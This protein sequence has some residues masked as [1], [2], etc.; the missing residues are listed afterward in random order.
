MLNVLTQQLIL[1][2]FLLGPVLGLTVSGTGEASLAW[3]VVAIEGPPLFAGGAFGLE[4]GLTVTFTT[5]LLIVLLVV[6]H[7]RKRGLA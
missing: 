2:G 4:G 6:A 1:C 3:T 5:G 7:L